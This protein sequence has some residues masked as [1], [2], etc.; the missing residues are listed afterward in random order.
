MSKRED[1]LDSLLKSVTDPESANYPGESDDEF[2]Q[3]FEEELFDSEDDQDFLRE[4]EGILDE[5]PVLSNDSGDFDVDTMN[6]SQNDVMVNTMDGSGFD[7]GFDSAFGQEF[8]SDPTPVSSMGDYDLDGM[9]ANAM[10]DQESLGEDSSVGEDDPELLDLLA[11]MSSDED[12]AEIQDLLNSHDSGSDIDLSE[13][14]DDFEG[15]IEI[16][17]PEVDTPKKKGL[18]KKI[19]TTLFGED[20]DQVE[21]PEAGEMASISEENMDVLKKMETK[22][23]KKQQKKE[24]KDQKEQDKQRKKEL[25]AQ[26]KAEKKQKA[27]KKK[28]EQ[29]QERI[30]TKRLPVI[31]VVLIF[32]MAGSFVFLIYLGSSLV[33][34]T[35][36][37]VQAENKYDLGDYTDAYHLLRQMKIKESDKEFYERAKLSSFVKKELDA[38]EVYAIKDMY[39]EAL[40]ALICA[41]GQYDKHKKDADAVG[42]TAEFD[43]MM[44]GVENVLQE[45]FKMTMDEAREI[46]RQ[47]DRTSYTKQLY[48]MLERAGLTPQTEE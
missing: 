18:L 48:T 27:E 15:P 16:S 12:L 21:I 9:L 7:G 33:G 3:K 26:K 39:P 2:L 38:Y 31:P 1:Y 30:K 42:A 20:E 36:G 28:E 8:E 46:Y 34:Y 40:D 19:S 14:P 6:F 5:K 4:F 10:S 44:S 17:T 47:E 32:V 23:K 13:F 25:R 29:E 35:S 11:G 41:V 22:E 43:L 24:K 45:A 37:M